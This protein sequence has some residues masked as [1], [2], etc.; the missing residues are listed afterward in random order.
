MAYLL[1]R[2]ASLTDEALEMHDRMVG[3][4]LAGAK[5]TRDESLKGRGKQVNEKVGLYAGV[6]NKA[7]ESG[8]DPYTLIE[9]FVPWERFVRSVEE[10]EDLA[11]PEAFD[12]L[13]HLK[14]HHRRLRKYAPLLF[15]SFDFSAVPPSAPLLRAVEVL[16]EMNA[17]RKRKVSDDAPTSFVKLRREPH[18]FAEDGSRSTRR[19]CSRSSRTA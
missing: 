9:E 1:K 7:R 18:V 13:E 2:A 17:A 15:E 19:A 14:D 12:F 16:E 10:A 11:L 4:A 3:E 8:D 5:R 6:G